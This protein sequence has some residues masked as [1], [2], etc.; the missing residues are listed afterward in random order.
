MSNH[1]FNLKQW[2]ITTLGVTNSIS[3]KSK[4]TDRS[5]GFL[6]A[7]N[8][9]SP[10]NLRD[11]IRSVK[12]ASLGFIDSWIFNELDSAEEMS[13]EAFGHIDYIAGELLRQRDVK[14]RDAATWP[15]SSLKKALSAVVGQL[16]VN[17][18]ADDLAWLQAQARG[19]GGFPT[20]AS[21]SPL[22]LEAALTKL[23]HRDTVAVNFLVN[24]PNTHFLYTVTTAGMGQATSVVEVDI[25]ALCEACKVAA[26]HV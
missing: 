22:N 20:G 13:H 25:R 7:L 24:S 11:S 4:M 14:R 15:D 5:I 18:S 10:R 26:S 19:A 1:S 6:V 2:G 3:L 16:M 21:P 9:H 17:V 23:K 12:S 8:G